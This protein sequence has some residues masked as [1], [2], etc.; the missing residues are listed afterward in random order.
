INRLKS[1]QAITNENEL[2]TRRNLPQTKVYKWINK[3]DHRMIEGILHYPPDKF[4]FQNLPLLV[5]IHGDPFQASLNVLN[6]VWYHWS[7]LAATEGWL[8]FEPNYR[9]STSYG[10]QFLDEIHGIADPQRLPV[11]GYSYGSFLTNW[12]ITQTK[13]FNAALSGAGVVD[14]TSMWGT[15]DQ[16]IMIHHLFGGLPC[17]VPY[18]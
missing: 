18:I 4:E 11:G 5:L 13:R 17:E 6:P 7:T 14:H 16:P 9:G 3:D 15:L 2:F 1:A 10:D 8:V 12:L